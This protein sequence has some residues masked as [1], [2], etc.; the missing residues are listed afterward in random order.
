MRLQ[1]TFFCI[2]YGFVIIAINVCKTAAQPNTSHPDTLFNPIENQAKTYAIEAENA[3][4]T[5]HDYKL[6]NDILS[7]VVKM[8][9]NPEYK[10]NYALTFF[11]L[12]N[13][14][15]CISFLKKTINHPEAVGITP[16]HYLLL[17]FCFQ[18]TKKEEKAYKTLLE[19]IEIFKNEGAIYEQLG[20]MEYAKKN[21]DKAV[22]WWEVGIQNSP[23]FSSNYYWCAKMFA[24]SSEPLWALFY[25]E[26]FVWLEPNSKR[27][28]ECKNLLYRLYFN[29]LYKKNPP[30]VSKRASTFLLLQ[31]IDNTPADSLPFQ[32]AYQQTFEYAALQT[33]KLCS[34]STQL[35]SCIYNFK[36]QFLKQWE[37]ENFQNIFPNQ[38]FTF[39][40]KIIDTQYFECYNYWLFST[41]NPAEFQTFLALNKP[42]FKK[43]IKWY[44]ANLPIF[45]HHDSFYR[46][47]FAK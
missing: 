31:N 45:S 42:Q 39:Y 6:A 37:K 41:A 18:E 3:I 11:Y 9:D 23:N 25:A 13:Y 38:L 43:F 40:K 14:E 22:E 15:K 34:D 4:R 10:Y 26:L 8:S 1:K 24:T 47:R 17:A 28:A 12:K 16:K 7:K 2:F 20:L 46:A 44:N 36:L 27:S 33:Q 32:V 35:I 19:A 5:K 29:L 30:T 21:N